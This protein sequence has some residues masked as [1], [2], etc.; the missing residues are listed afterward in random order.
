MI[1]AMSATNRINA[2]LALSFVASVILLLKQINSARLDVK[3]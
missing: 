2:L 3:I 1:I